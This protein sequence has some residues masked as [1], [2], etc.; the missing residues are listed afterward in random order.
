MTWVG[1]KAPRSKC[2]RLA[3]GMTA[4]GVLVRTTIGMVWLAPAP[5]AAPDLAKRRDFLHA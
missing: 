4:F 2:G 1:R 3:V 5:L